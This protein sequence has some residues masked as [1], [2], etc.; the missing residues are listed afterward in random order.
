MSQKI[1]LDFE[2]PPDLAGLRLDQALAKCL[3]DYSRANIQ[4]WVKSGQITVNEQT[5]R[6]RDKVQGEEQIALRVELET[7]EDHAQD[8]PLNIIHEDEEIIVIDKPAGLVVHPGAG[9]PN[10]TLVNALL[11]HHPAA[12]DL[13]RAGI[14]HR[15]DKDTSGL[16]VIAK[17][18][19]SHN[20][21]VKAIQ[22][23]EVKRHYI[24]IVN[25]QF[26]AGGTIDAP[27][28][29]HPHN[30]LKMAITHNGKTAITH[31]R[32]RQKY[33]EHTALDIELE[34]GR[35]HQIRVHFASKQ[36]PLIG[37]KIYGYRPHFPKSCS[38]ELKDILRNF[39]RQAL[40]ASQLKLTHPT[41]QEELAF[42]SELPEDIVLLCRLLSE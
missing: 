40:H 27:I 33:I 34:T 42:K 28:G 21:L 29:R 19:A 23:R 30:R 2:I 8:I 11:F 35:T 12:E 17:T 15:L 3:P 25:G 1:H 32:I 16:M 14:V 20:A 4:S 37:D 41:T 39:P 10:N 22:N 24:A 13:P 18:L 7:L 9:N 38:E 5:A 6:N 31:Y 36:H 26:I